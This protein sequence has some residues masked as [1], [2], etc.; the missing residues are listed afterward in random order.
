MD[1]KLS[2]KRPLPL[3][4][5]LFL[6]LSFSPLVLAETPISINTQ[7]SASD[8]TGSHQPNEFKLP[9]PGDISPGA[10]IESAEGKPVDTTKLKADQLGF[11]ATAFPKL[12]RD[13]LWGRY[14]EALPIA[15]SEARD[16]DEK[17]EGDDEKLTNI[18]VR[19]TGSISDVKEEQL[20][21]GQVEKA[22]KAELAKPSPDHGF[23]A[24]LRRVKAAIY[25]R[26]GK[27]LVSDPKWWPNE[28]RLEA[29][30]RKLNGDPQVNENDGKPHTDEEL[31][32]LRAY[33]KKQLAFW[34]AIQTVAT[35]TGE[36]AKAGL[37]H[38]TELTSASGLQYF[39]KR[40]SEAFGKSQDEGLKRWVGYVSKVQAAMAHPAA[41]TRTEPS[42]PNQPAALI[43]QPSTQ[44]RTNLK[45]ETIQQAFN[46][47]NCT[48]CHSV[49]TVND[50]L[51]VSVNIPDSF[52]NARNA[53]SS[54][55]EKKR[56]SHRTLLA[57]L[58]HPD[59]ADLSG[60][61]TGALSPSFREQLRQWIAQIN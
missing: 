20:T 58:K 60:G 24:L 44:A 9:S 28:E 2:L 45:K 40:F 41:T 3:A 50:D 15:M 46:Q 54:D 23:L 18:I 5:S 4:L 22:W 53:A 19:L 52:P 29:F 12:S 61:Q 39:F 27:P 11:L 57:V 7:D 42:H 8:T 48:S 26:R 35:Q 51:T 6:V 32:K 33:R 37:A 43:H 25:V 38:L 49:V 30:N 36:T 47:Q 34:A 14:H 21:L 16:Y 56:F 10:A 31:G 59:H 13:E 55:E 17:D 1:L